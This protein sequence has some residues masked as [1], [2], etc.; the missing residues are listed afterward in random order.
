MHDDLIARV[1]AT[2]AALRGMLRGQPAERLTTRAEAGEWAPIDV[3]VHIRASSAIV[4]PRIMQALVRERP[5]FQSLDEVEWA[6]LLALPEMPLDA[7]LTAFQLERAELTAILMKLD[8]SQ[9]QRAGV[10]EQR[11]EQSVRDICAQLAEHE[12]EHIAHLRTMLDTAL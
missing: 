7:Q 4:A 5:A 11:G 2:P 8:A 3:V 12:E 1:R 9:W 6:R 10:H